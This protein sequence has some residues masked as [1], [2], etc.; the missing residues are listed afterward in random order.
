M[1]YEQHR[2]V[3]GEK[4]TAPMLNEI[5][6]E[7]DE[8]DEQIED[9]SHRSHE[10]MRDALI[11]YTSVD[12]IER[13]VNT[14]RQ[15][16]DALQAEI[17]SQQ[18]VQDY[19][20]EQML[21]MAIDIDEH[22]RRLEKLDASKASAIALEGALAGIDVNSARIDDVESKN[23]ENAERIDELA[24]KIAEADERKVD[25]TELDTLPAMM[26]DVDGAQR[27]IEVLKQIKADKVDVSDLHVEIDGVRRALDSKADIRPDAQTPALLADVDRLTRELDKKIG[28]EHHANEL[29]GMHVEMDRISREMDGK[30]DHSHGINDIGS[31]HVEVDRIDRVVNSQGSTISGLQGQVATITYG[32]A[33]KVEKPRGEGHG[34]SGQLLSTNG[35]GT[36]QWVDPV[37]VSDDQVGEAVSDWLNDHPEATTTVAD[38][39]ITEEK[40]SPELADKIGNSAEARDDDLAIVAL[41]A[42]VQLESAA[43]SDIITHL[44]FYRGIYLRLLAYAEYFNG[45]DGIGFLWFT[46]PHLMGSTFGET[47]MSMLEGLREIRIAFENSPA[48][49]VVCGGDWLCDDHT[50]A[51]AKMFSGRIGNL[52]RGWIGERAYTVVG[53]HDWGYLAPPAN[54]A[55]SET[56]VARL[57]RHEDTA[58]YIISDG[59]TDC[60]MLDSGQD[61]WPMSA[62]Q[63]AEVDWFAAK[64]LANSAAHLFGV[65]HVPPE[66]PTSSGQESYVQEITVNLCAVAD[67]FNRRASIEVNGVTYDFRNGN[68]T[69]HFMLCGHVHAD[70]I[71]KSNNIPL[72]C[73]RAFYDGRSFDCCYADFD[74]SVL[75][76]VRIGNGESRDFNII[77]N[78]GYSADNE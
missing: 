23:T 7:I 30:A 45:G 43:G 29:A 34:A 38:G 52:M 2:W 40:L 50:M 25:R 42:Q 19:N 3:T 60:Y 48:R 56:E 41:T 37:A 65:I 57:W 68:G 44:S 63:W 16:I 70:G 74:A 36:T 28:P 13:Q 9:L 11:L 1:A 51:Q 73:T 54:M 31:M 78:G 49:Y 46:D 59:N 58:Y 72:F 55:L 75:H 18:V 14:N 6:A 33:D 53:N 5:E 62:Y 27:D 15:D 21:A 61:T 39:S 22:D 8:H 69:M 77:P 26:V 24:D 12:E 76:M 4:I 20:R 47:Q 10:A 64:L 17:G 66:I 32:M 67:A 71:Y 35:D